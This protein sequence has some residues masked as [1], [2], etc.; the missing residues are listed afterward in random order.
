STAFTI[1]VVESFVAGFAGMAVYNINQVS[2]RQAIT[3]L[4][5]QG[6]MNSAM[7]FMVWGTMPIGAMI[8]GILGNRIGL[9][10]TLWVGA[11]GGLFA[12]LPPLLSPVRSLQRIPE[13]EGD[14]APGRLLAD[15]AGVVDVVGVVHALESMDEGVVEPGHAPRA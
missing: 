15:V 13:P 7:R 4:R 3:P 1:L 14:E 9:R 6:R 8:G 12:F 11:I 5:M 10:P 2:L